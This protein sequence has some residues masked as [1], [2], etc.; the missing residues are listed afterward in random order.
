MAAAFFAR[1]LNDAPGA[2]TGRA[3]SF[4]GK[5]SLLRADAAMPFAHAAIDRRGA[6][7]RA[8]ALAI[9]TGD[10]V[11]DSD[12]PVDARKSFLE[13]NVQIVT[14]IGAALGA[15]LLTAATAENFAEHFV[16][17]IGEARAEIEPAAHAAAALLE[18]RMPKT[19]I[20]GAAL[21][22]A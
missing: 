7:C 12:L 14:K 4:D 21:I 2:L 15:L 10:G 17:D 6:G 16:E 13:R 20:G 18:R 8:A 5:E 19:V 11:G 3:G 1:A 22:V 9:V